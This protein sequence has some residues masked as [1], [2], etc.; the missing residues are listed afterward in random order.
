MTAVASL[1]IIHSRS[2]IL[3]DL[4]VAFNFMVR[5]RYPHGILMHLGETAFLSEIGNSFSHIPFTHRIF[6]GAVTLLLCLFFLSR[7]RFF[8]F[9]LFSSASN[10]F[11]AL[12]LA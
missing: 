11:I 1:D 3:G 2:G 8:L 7:R 6:E 10:F 4:K 12:T 9:L 5:N